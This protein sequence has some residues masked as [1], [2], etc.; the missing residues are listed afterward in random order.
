MSNVTVVEEY[1][2]S[3]FSNSVILMM[4]GIINMNI[5]IN[6]FKF[7]CRRNRLTI[8]EAKNNVVTI[9]FD[10]VYDVEKVSENKVVIKF[11]IDEKIIIK[12][13]V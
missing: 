9:S 6:N 2:K 5:K 3:F 1:L 8:K 11:N 10:E 12:T 7:I 13:N 4:T